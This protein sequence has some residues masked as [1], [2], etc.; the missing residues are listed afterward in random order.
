MALAKL[1]QL[2]HFTVFDCANCGMPFAVTE[3]FEG[4]RRTD[5]ESFC[6]PRGHSQSFT[7]SEV[8]K[9]KKQLEEKEKA[10]QREKGWRDV[11]E[12]GR[13]N[14]EKS[15]SAYKGKVTKIKNRIHNGVCP[16]CNR[17]FQNLKRHM[18]TQ[19]PEFKKEP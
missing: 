9:L 8:K 13:K 3:E 11:A 5:G 12:R 14:A 15:A 2:I 7:D 19:H 4:R 10:L 17:S 18:A 6:C 16:C 1:T